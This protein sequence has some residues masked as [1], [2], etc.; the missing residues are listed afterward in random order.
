MNDLKY[1]KTVRAYGKNRQCNNETNMDKS[2]TVGR[3]KKAQ[4][5]AV[6]EE[7][8]KNYNGAIRNRRRCMTK[9]MNKMSK[10]GQ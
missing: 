3:P 10:K 2:R 8:E 6:N 1:I 4:V 7:L 5:D 9:C